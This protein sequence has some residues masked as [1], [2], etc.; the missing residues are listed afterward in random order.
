MLFWVAYMHKPNQNKQKRITMKTNLFKIL[1]TILLLTISLQAKNP[2]AVLETN[3]GNIEIELL[4]NK[5]PKAVENFIGL[6]K[7]GYYNGVIFHRIIK[8]F[9]IQGG[10]PTGTGRGG[11]SIWGKDF[12]DEF[13]PNVVFDKKGI[14]AMANAGPNTNKSQFFIT[15]APT[16]WL[17]GHHTIFGY[18]TKDSM[19]V[20][21]KL[22][23]VEVAYQNRPVK[24]QVITKAYI[25]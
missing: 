7:K 22:G 17:N 21:E 5:A 12:K 23:N 13:A 6:I 19:K 24:K 2:I 20:V 16:P 3:A 9:M 4:A 14:L 18:V 8:G 25:K 11:T 10:D 1:L 15:L